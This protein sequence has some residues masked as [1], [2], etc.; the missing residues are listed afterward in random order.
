MFQHPL[1]SLGGNVSPHRGQNL[2]AMMKPVY[3]SVEHKPQAEVLAYAMLHSMS[4]GSYVT[5]SL[6]NQ[7]DSRDHSDA[8]LKLS[9]MTTVNADLATDEYNALRVRGF[10]SKDRHPIFQDRKSVV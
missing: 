4:N 10:Y 3:V 9:T 8:N 5:S 1:I 7:L 2:S 6:L